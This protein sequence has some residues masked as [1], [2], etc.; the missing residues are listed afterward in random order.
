M[1][2]CVGARQ[3]YHH[4]RSALAVNRN[5]RYINW[6]KEGGNTDWTLA[7]TSS[8]NQPHLL[9]IVRLR[10]VTWNL[11]NVLPLPADIIFNVHRSVG[12]PR[13][14]SSLQ[15]GQG[16]NMSLTDRAWQAHSPSLPHS[17]CVCVCVR[18]CVTVGL[19]TTPQ[20]SWGAFPVFVLFLDGRGC[21]GPHVCV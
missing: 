15:R 10:E 1:R 7:L 20:N 18:V 19:G 9:H 12:R 21:L 3:L 8:E 2:L 16:W 14:K 4:H 13:P 17:V 11:R 5:Q 6:K